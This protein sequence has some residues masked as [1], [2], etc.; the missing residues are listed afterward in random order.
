M[1]LLFTIQ[2]VFSIFFFCWGV[3]GYCGGKEERTRRLEGFA[4]QK[5]DA[6][7]AKAAKKAAEAAK[8]VEEGKPPAAGA[9]AGSHAEVV[10]P[11]Q[12]EVTTK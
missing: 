6:K 9:A 8:K 2:A 10:A 3:C 4:K 1:A 7:A 5:E 12:V 11:Q